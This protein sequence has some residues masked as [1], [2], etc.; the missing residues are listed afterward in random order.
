MGLDPVTAVSDLI[1]TGLNKFVRDKVSEDV[2]EKIDNNFKMHVLT[3][4]NKEKGAFR[5][6]ILAYEGSISDYKNFKFIGPIVVLA[7]GLIRPLFTYATGY[8]DWIFFSSDTTEWDPLKIKLLFAINL[9]VLIFWFG[10]RL[11]KN[12]GI[13]E[14]LFKMFLPVKND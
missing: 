7:R 11:L 1:K 6:F 4:S 2:M 12:T 8:W 14:I 3:E 10:E 9:I 5:N 13:A